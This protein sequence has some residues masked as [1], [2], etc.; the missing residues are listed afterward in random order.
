MLR[1]NFSAHTAAAVSVN[2]KNA[3]KEYSQQ[4]QRKKERE[5]LKL[6]KYGGNRQKVP[7]S[8]QQHWGIGGHWTD[9]EFMHTEFAV[10]I[11]LFVVF[12]THIVVASWPRV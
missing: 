10:T 1:A 9:T 12:I 8:T 7:C 3:N 6:H 5:K 11:Y 2:A 4:Q